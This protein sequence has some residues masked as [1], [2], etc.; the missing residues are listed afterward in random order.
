MPNLLDICADNEFDC[1][2]GYCA[3]GSSRCDGFY[4]CPNDIDEENCSK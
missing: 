3:D 4:D 1:G 2:G